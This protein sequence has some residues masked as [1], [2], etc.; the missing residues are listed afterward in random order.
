MAKGHRSQIKKERNIPAENFGLKRWDSLG[1][2]LPVILGTK[3]G[4]NQ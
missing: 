2:F 3:I 4:I 1:V